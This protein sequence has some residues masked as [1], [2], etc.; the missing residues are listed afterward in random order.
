MRDVAS[1]ARAARQRGDAIGV[2]AEQL[3]D[4]DLQ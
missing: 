3:L 2:Y 4:T 1:P